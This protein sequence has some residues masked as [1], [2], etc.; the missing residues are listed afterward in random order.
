MDVE[1]G[2]KIMFSSYEQFPATAAMCKAF[3]VNMCYFSNIVL[4]PGW[5]KNHHEP[6]LT[7]VS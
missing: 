6:K 5:D 1:W 2:H 3:P 7:T 4:F